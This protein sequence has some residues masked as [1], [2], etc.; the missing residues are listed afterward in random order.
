MFLR[1]S[2]WIILL[3]CFTFLSPLLYASENEEGF[4]PIFNEKDLSGWEGDY[5]YWSVQD[6]TITGEIT[7]DLPGDRN[8]FLEWKLGPV[9]DFELR[10]SYRIFD[11]NSGVQYRSQ[12]EDHWH[13]EGYQAD[14]EAGQK[15]TGAT[16]DEHGRGPLAM[17]GEKTIID[18]EGNKTTEQFADPDELLSH[19]KQ[20]DWNEYTIIARGNHLVNIINGHVMSEVIDNQ[21]S[22]NDHIG[23]LALQLHSGP[24][25][26]VQFKNL[27]LKRY[28][29]EHKK[30][31]VMVAG[32]RSH[33]HGQHE[34]NAGVLLLKK[35]LEQNEDMIAATYHDG[36]P[37]DP[38]A[39]DNPDTILIFMDG[40]ARHFFLQNN[41][42]QQL[43]ACMERGVG[44]CVLHYAL[45][46]ENNTGTQEMLDWIGGYYETG[47]ST[48]PIWEAKFKEL[49]KH[50]ITR[51]VEPFT[52]KD[53]WYY[54]IR[55]RPE[56][57]NVT[58]LLTAAPPD[59]TRGTQAA[60]EHP[61]RDEIVSW[62]AKREDGGRG[63][64]FTGGH[65]HNNWGDENYRKFVLNAL[66]WTA[67]VPVPSN[68]VPSTINEE[69]LE[70][71]LDLNR[72][73]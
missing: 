55:F 38:S 56:M 47:Y 57:E 35:C 27:R 52:L 65:Y 5:R 4:H 15:W 9:D 44:L 20:E 66:Y 54:N 24:P 30:K 72:E 7:E 32:P 46:P 22:E 70:E 11:G 67:H 58:P 10:F 42:M 25:M 6:G 41:S 69:F 3:L 34:H 31:A 21:S 39:F 16:Y 28:N 14:F 29:L 62:C 26:K 63:F 40:N 51:G 53:E 68:G 61:G 73:R 2:H 71:N 33:G 49:P 17:R 18:E 60:K 12:V 48:N 64:G 45:D 13:V 23:S 50:P 8:Q 43:S 19:V 1:T 37:H 59:D 36:W